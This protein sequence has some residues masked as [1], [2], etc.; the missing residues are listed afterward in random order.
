MTGEKKRDDD[1]KTKTKTSK[2]NKEIKK[3]TNAKE[4]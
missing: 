2:K 3:L 4:G 1:Y